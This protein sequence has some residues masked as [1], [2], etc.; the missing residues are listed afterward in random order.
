MLRYLVMLGFLYRAN[1]IARAWK[2]SHTNIQKFANADL[3][4]WK[5][6]EGSLCA[7]VPTTKPPAPES[8][9]YLIKCGCKKGCASKSCSCKK[10]F[11]CCTEACACT[12]FECSNIEPMPISNI[13]D[14]DDTELDMSEGESGKINIF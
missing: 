10:N 6:M 7:A 2:L 11:L 1:F 13:N 9:L 8:L 5:K 14:D 4:G 12:E 3:C